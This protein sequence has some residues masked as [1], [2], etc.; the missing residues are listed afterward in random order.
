MATT[1][2]DQDLIVTGTFRAN[3][4]VLPSVARTALVQNDDLVFP[5]R[6]SDA[7]VWDAFG[8]VLPTTGSSDDLGLYTGTFGTDNPYISSGDVKNATTTR[9]ARFLIPVP[10]CY[11]SG[12]SL[13][14]RAAAGMV[15]TAASSSA[16]IDFEA[17][18]VGRAT[19]KSGSDLVATSAISINTV[20]FSNRDF[21]LTTSTITPGLLL[22]V[23]VTIAVVDVATGTA[24]TP[25]L[26]A[27]DL[28]ADCQG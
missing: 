16:T 7:R 11:V 6:L 25:V 15:T 13:T 21:T 19:H 14:L 24:V 27:L 22:D 8:T 28:L 12:Q 3:G 1:V 2:I 4:G 10:E 23:R 17:Y 5:V 9:Y 20:G 26:A 18:L